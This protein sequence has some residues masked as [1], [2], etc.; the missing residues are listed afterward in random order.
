MNK[1]ADWID[2]LK[3]FACI[4]VVIGH[5]MQSFIISG[6][7]TNVELSKKIIFV[8]YL[9]HMPLFLYSSGYLYFNYSNKKNTKRFLANKFINLFVPYITFYVLYMTFNTIFSDNVN[10]ARG[11]AGWL[12]IINNPI[13]P[14][15]FLYSLF[16]IIC[17]VV[18]FEKFIKNYKIG[19]LIFAIM[20]VVSVF[21]KCKLFF[22]YSIMSDGIYFYLGKKELPNIKRF[23]SYGCCILLIVLSILLYTNLNILSNYAIDILSIMLSCF[24]VLCF[25][26]I[27]KNNNGN[28]VLNFIGKYSFYI[29]L[30]HTF[31]AAGIR[32]IFL[33]I[34]IT[35]YIIHFIIGLLF[36]L[37]LPIFV[38]ISSKKIG[39][40]EIFFYPIQTVNKYN[41]K[42]K[43]AK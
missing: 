2:N 41:N 40:T 37:F 43:E 17:F 12:G 5:L 36:S 20:K 11:I 15:W 21:W 38:G 29:F 19:L 28:V 6:I 18:V 1:R 23:V 22:V 31:F 26:C 4:L 13:S 30:I 8:I 32:V 14:Y 16:F 9:I 39:F 33:K 7:D 24:F 3:S 34:G 10:S 35:N 42:K 27:F 25:T